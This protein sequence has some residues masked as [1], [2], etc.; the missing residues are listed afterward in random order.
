MNDEND[1]KKHVIGLSIALMVLCGMVYVH[2]ADALP[3]VG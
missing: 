2:T 3:V 1:F